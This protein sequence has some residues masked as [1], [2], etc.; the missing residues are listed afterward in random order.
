LQALAHQ[1]HGRTAA[2]LAS[3]ERA[4]ALAEPE[5]YVRI[6]VDEGPRMAELLQAA[7][8]RGIAIDY[9]R[10]L[11]PRFGA[12][13]QRARSEQPSSEVEPLSERELDVLRLLASALD[14]PDIAR[15]LTVSL[16][17]MRTHTRSIFNKLGVNN[18]R[19]AVRRAEELRIIT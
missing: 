12:A 18:R 11:L 17:T 1:Q 6:F 4:L 2:A 5:G 7:V 3:L 8:K 16:S 19:E 9:V 13:E 10:A 14:G 15:E